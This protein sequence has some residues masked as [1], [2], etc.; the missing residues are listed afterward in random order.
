MS[1]YILPTRNRI[2]RLTLTLAALGRLRGHEP[3]A[4]VIVVDNASHDAPMLP[5]TLP[6]GLTV[7]TILRR[8]NEGAASRNAGVQACNPRHDWVVMLDDDGM[9]CQGPR[10]WIEVPQRHHTSETG[11]SG[12]SGAVCWQMSPE[13]ATAFT[14]LRLDLPVHSCSHDCSCRRRFAMAGRLMLDLPGT[15]RMLPRECDNLCRI[16]APGQVRQC[17]IGR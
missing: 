11:R 6:N 8:S 15:A 9:P 10:S 3:G 12:P 17:R 4:E 7:R 13:A 1:S 2:E 16:E 14:S 5:E